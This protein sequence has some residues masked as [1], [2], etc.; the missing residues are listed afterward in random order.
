MRSLGVWLS[1]YLGVCAPLAAHAQNPVES[2]ASESI[3]TALLSESLTLRGSE[4]S[5]DLI[6]NL[7]DPSERA[8]AVEL[9]LPISVSEHVLG[10]ST[11][12]LELQDQPLQSVFVRQ[13]AARGAWRIALPNLP[14]GYFALRLRSRLL[15]AGDP[16]HDTPQQVPTLT[17]HA[18]AA[19]LYARRLHPP[20]PPS[21]AALLEQWRQ[22]H[23]PVHLVRSAEIDRSEAPAWLAADFFL[24]SLG[25]LPVASEALPDSTSPALFLHA[26]SAVERAIEIPSSDRSHGTAQVEGRSLHVRAS[27]PQALQHALYALANPQLAGR[28]TASICQVP[29]PVDAAS[30]T[31][32]PAAESQD[33]YAEVFTLGERGYR[34]GYVVR[35]EGEHVLALPWVRPSWWQVSEW[36]ELDMMLSVS[37]HP[38]LDAGA[39]EVELR[40]GSR[41]LEHAALPSPGPEPLRLSARIPPSLWNESDWPLQIRIVLR[42]TPRP[43]CVV[44]QGALWAAIHS[45][46]RLRVP[47][48]EQV[49]RGSLAGFASLARR[50]RPTLLWPG[51]LPAWLLPAIGAAIYPWESSGPLELVSDRAS[52]AA[53]CVVLTGAPI[54]LPTVTS[55]GPAVRLQAEPASAAQATALRLLWSDGRRSE[56]ALRS[57]EYASLLTPQAEPATGTFLSQGTAGRTLPGKRVHPPGAT[58]DGERIAWSKNVRWLSRDRRRWRGWL[59]ASFLFALPLLAGLCWRVTSRRPR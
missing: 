26:Y 38:A 50:Q 42:A 55:E 29:I 58:G 36:P 59:D 3:R 45:R 32:P 48:Q 27:D 19:L 53:P 15:T 5:A 46:S 13:L 57:P 11:L 43:D 44:P 10:T 8:S 9:E 7:P 12:T 18:T 20:A 54:D 39:S 52:C 28:C 40:F 14:A 37:P 31:P 51:A 49:Y 35:G 30:P 24:R 47:R 21:V 34:S 25:A 1:L 16:C 6:M 4:G 17:L 22:Q 2:P 23:P 33:T 41:R 56:V